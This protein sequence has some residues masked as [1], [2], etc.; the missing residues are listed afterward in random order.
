MVILIKAPKVLVLNQFLEKRFERITGIK[1]KLQNFITPEQFAF[2][3]GTQVTK[4]FSIVS[5]SKTMHGYILNG[6]DLRI[7]PAA[8]K[9]LSKQMIKRLQAESSGDFSK[10]GNTKRITASY[11]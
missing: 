3:A 7:H 6:A 1:C 8:L 10:F 5:K 11:R 4:V 9:Y 2:V